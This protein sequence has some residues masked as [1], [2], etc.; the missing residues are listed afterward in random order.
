MILMTTSLVGQIPFRTVYL[1]GLVRDTN[2][3]KLSKSKADSANPLDIIA[4]YGA[5]ALRFALIFNTSPGTDSIL[6]DEKVRGMQHFANK[7]WN[8]TRFVLGQIQTDDEGTQMYSAQIPVAKTDA[9]RLIIEQL[10]RTVDEATNNLDSFRLH[11]AA[12]GIYD[13]VW[14]EFADVYIEA[15]KAQMNDEEHKK[16]TMEILYFT[17][18]TSLKLLHPFMP[19]VTEAIWSHMYG[20]EKML[21]VEH[22]PSLRPS[23]ALGATAGKPE[24]V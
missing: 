19:F 2:R 14:H 17:L 5:D 4:K 7:V 6:S 21:M 23:T 13:F 24:V 18:T 9:D 3:Q 15:S 12:Q 22:W 8:I 20:T 11:E 10:R 1:H 16:S